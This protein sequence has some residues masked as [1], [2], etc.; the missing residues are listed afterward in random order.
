MARKKIKQ[1]LNTLLNIEKP[2]ILFLSETKSQ[3]PLVRKILN[4]F[5]NHHIVDPKGTAGGLALAWV[6]GFHFEIVQWNLNMINVLVKNNYNSVEWLLTCFYGSPKHDMKLEVMGNLENIAH[7]INLNSM[8]WLVI[9]DLNIILNSEEKEGGL[10]F[11]RTKM[12]HILNLIQRTGLEDLG[13]K[14]NIFTWSNNRQG[15]A[16]IKQRLDRAMA[17]A[18]WNIEFK[19]ASL[20]N[21]VAIGSDHGPICLSLQPVFIPLSHC[22]KFYDT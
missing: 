14:R 16:N 7:R 12:N 6:D 11:N 8:P 13:Y 2:D 15:M 5:P 17:N 21:L 3:R 20:G 4:S 1:H 9:G 18:Q 10:P 22:F 19:E